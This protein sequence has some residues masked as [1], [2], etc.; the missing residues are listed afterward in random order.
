MAAVEDNRKETRRQRLAV[1]G[2][3]GSIG[4]QTLEVV[5]AWP[6]LFEVEMLAAHRNWELL[7]R[8]AEEFESGGCR[9]LFAFVTQLRRLLDEMEV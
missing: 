5:R 1:L 6:E 8:Q 2:S 4:T 3:T 9:G 7:A